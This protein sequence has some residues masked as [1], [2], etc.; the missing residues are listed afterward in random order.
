[1]SARGSDVDIEKDGTAKVEPE[2]VY[3]GK[4][5]QDEDDL[6]PQN[7]VKRKLKARHLQMIALGGTIGT[8]LFVGAGSALATGGAAGIFLGYSIVGMIVYAVMV[9]LGE[10]TALY[11]VNGAF[12]HYASRF[13]DPSLGFALGWNY[14]Y[15]WAITIPTEIV[16]AAL[17]LDY[18]PGAA[19]VNVAVWI[20]VFF[21]VI[22]A[23][24]FM[25]VGTY[26][27]AEFWFALIKIV[28]LLGLIIVALIITAGGVPTSNPSEYPIGFRY[29]NEV[30]F[31]QQNGIPGSLGRFLS[32]WT[33]F[34]QASFSFLGTEIVALTAG[35]AENPRR[36][37]P[38]AIKRVFA[39]IVFFYVVGVFMMSLIVSPN[40][41]GLLNNSGTAASPWVIGI[42]KAGIK[43]LPHIVNA[44]ILTAAFSAGNSDLYAASRTLYG[45]ARDGQAPR[46]FAKCTKNGL[47]I[48]SLVA[49]ASVGFL[50]YMNCGTGGE[51][52]FN[53][54]VAI[55]SVTGLISWLV[56]L[57]TYLRFYYGARKQGIDR[58]AFP[59]TAPLQPW[60]SYAA[61]FMITV[62]IIFSDYQV[63]LTDS[64]DIGSFLSAYITIPWF[65]LMLIAWKVWKKTTFVRLE[66][67]DFSSGRR[68]LDLMEE[69]QQKLWRA[70]QTWWEKVWDWL[71]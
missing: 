25:G 1:M 70:P 9:A 41:P 19:R 28:T 68:A 43:V 7:G 57:I 36:N 35:E 71:M 45:L 11:P 40:D 69:E 24:N 22:T 15:N 6:G 62:I 50:A 12:V 58:S 5:A 39:R 56:I 32:F 46:I 63:F 10:M 23:F 4:E 20:T 26:G 52:A 48:W 27:E 38:K 49:T 64:W 66:S 16:A 37:V 60:A 14:W 31:Q 34:L 54:L 47:P 53:Y 67:M 33:V 21:I 44:V 30:P 29:W 65:F 55:A 51:R 13:V 59:Y 8:G 2:R 61:A 17:V 3:G 42:E 18:W